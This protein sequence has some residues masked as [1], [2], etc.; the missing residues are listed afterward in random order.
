MLIL[1]QHWLIEYDFMYPDYRHCDAFGPGHSDQLY[2]IMNL[3]K[4]HWRGPVYNESLCCNWTVGL[5]ISHTCHIE[6]L[7]PLSARLR[8]PQDGLFTGVIDA[9]DTVT[10]T[11]RV[12]FDRQGLGTYSIPDYEVLVSD[13]INLLWPSD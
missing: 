6:E 12:T 2:W 5:V 4:L 1:W 8:S 13:N 7:L 9:L 11:Y 10:N 3:T